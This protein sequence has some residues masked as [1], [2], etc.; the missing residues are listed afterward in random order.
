MKR[1]YEMFVW[2]NCN[3]FSQGH[4]HA[5]NTRKK[6]TE[7]FTIYKESLLCEN[8]IINMIYITK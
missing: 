5:F 4:I 3:V 7:L 6:K 8:S 1:Q 2:N